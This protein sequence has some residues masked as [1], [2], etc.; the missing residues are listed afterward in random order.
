MFWQQ[1][2]DTVVR[3]ERSEHDNK[4]LSTLSEGAGLA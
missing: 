1:C 2:Q 4:R 3:I